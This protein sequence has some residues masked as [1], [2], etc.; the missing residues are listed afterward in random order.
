MQLPNNFK[1]PVL[2]LFLSL[3]TCSQFAQ[4]KTADAE[5]PL[6]IEAD[7]VEM[8]EQ[9]GVSIYRGHVKISRGSMQIL[10]ELIYI[11]TTE[12]KLKKIRV[13]G[14]PAKFRQLNDLDEEISAQSHEME[15]QANDGVLIL[16]EKALLIQKQNRFASEH[17]IYD[18][19]KDI[20]QAGERNNGDN[21]T[22]SKP[23]R[24]TITI[25][26]EKNQTEQTENKT[27]SPQ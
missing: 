16:K 20:V 17:I 11:H 19:K 24:V 8:R 6:N 2:L 27:D 26:P 5:Q 9:E 22:D 10:G 18:T 7:A 1:P 12:N 3:V 4:A 13:V 21:A 23:E 14:T 15:Y 25:H